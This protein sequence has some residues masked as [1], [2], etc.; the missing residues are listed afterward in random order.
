MST[1]LFFTPEGLPFSVWLTRNGIDFQPETTGRINHFALNDDV[2]IN[3]SIIG[4]HKCFVM[5]PLDYSKQIPLPELGMGVYQKKINISL[6]QGARHLAKWP[7]NMLCV[8]V[9]GQ[10]YNVGIADQR[11]FFYFVI[12]NPMDDTEEKTPT[13][14]EVIW[15][16]PLH[17]IGAIFY[18]APVLHH[19]IHWSSIPKRENGCRYVKSGEILSWKPEDVKDVRDQSTFLT[20]V[21]N[22]E[23]VV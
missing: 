13:M 2:R 19:R 9:S 21:K 3:V 23:L 11:G 6:L 18:G 12:E 17:G 4:D 20:E 8:E 15:Y 22:A 1:N 5:D 16:S 14:G 7:K 10:R